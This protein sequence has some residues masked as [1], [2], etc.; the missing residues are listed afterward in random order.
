MKPVTARVK[1][2]RDDLSFGRA[3]SHERTSRIELVRFVPTGSGFTPYF[4]VETTDNAEF[5]A[6]VTADR[7]VDSLTCVAEEAGRYLYHVEWTLRADPFLRALCEEQIAVENAVGVRDEWRF[8]LRCPTHDGFRAFQNA[9]RGHGISSTV[10]GVWTTRLPVRTGPTM[11]PKQRR[12]LELAFREG[13]FDI[14]ARTNLTE[15]AEQVD[16]SRQSYTRRLSRGL[17][18]LLEDTLMTES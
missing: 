2:P 18:R 8:V 1:I 12:A 13:Y 17:H 5:E 9:L 14:P 3:L 6:V 15:L 10:L 4:W 7:V 16:I 11:T